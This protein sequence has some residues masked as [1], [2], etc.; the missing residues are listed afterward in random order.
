MGDMILFAQYLLP[1]SN[2]KSSYQVG[3]GY[4]L[5]TGAAD[6]E[7]TRGI[8]YNM[9]MQPGSGSMDALF[10]GAFDRRFKAIPSMSFS[11]RIFYRLNGKYNNFLDGETFQFGNEWQIIAGLGKQWL[12]WSQIFNTSVML[13]VRNMDKN[14]INGFSVSNT[15]GTW[16]NLITSLKLEPTQKLS[17]SL[18][19]EIPVYSELNGTQL[20]TSY[21]IR[22]AL[23][24]YFKDLQSPF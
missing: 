12:L 6:I 5:S 1:F 21:R 11:S 2:L 8:A 4:K 23:T 19:P 24:V 10:F 18:I 14:R 16:I 22:A 17:I 7:N 3:V 15:G 20:T 13:K 9:D